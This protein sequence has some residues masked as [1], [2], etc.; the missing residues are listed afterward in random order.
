M[1]CAKLKDSGLPVIIPVSMLERECG[2]DYGLNFSVARLL[3]MS[4]Q[5][6]QNADNLSTFC[7]Q[8]FLKRMYC[9]YNMY[10]RGYSTPEYIVQ[11]GDQT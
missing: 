8:S 9:I 11:E 6:E 10:L 5:S 4:T 3:V 7:Q 1:P 2:K